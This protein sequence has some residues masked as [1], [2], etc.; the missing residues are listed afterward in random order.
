MSPEFDDYLR[1]FLDR[2]PIKTDKFIA[3]AMPL[4]TRISRRAAPWLPEDLHGE[5][6]DQTFV[7]LLVSPPSSFDPTETSAVKFIRRKLFNAI[8]QVK[9]SYRN[10]GQSSRGRVYRKE[11]A[12]EETA[13]E[14]A[15][16]EKKGV[17]VKKRFASI[18]STDA[19]SFA[20]P[21]SWQGAEAIEMACDAATIL[22]KAP[23]V[24]G[25]AL[26]LMH[27]EGYTST[28]TADMLGISRAGMYAKVA[29]FVQSV[30]A[31]A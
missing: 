22:E 10:P 24:V 28:E 7:N 2:D 5:V 26:W 9:E 17:K 13:A 19:E 14:A 3:E 23:P 29:D 8:R 12:V 21:V 18:V 27:C 16:V 25:D 30:R 11:A 4:M 6:V 31:A 20:E 15:T 1:G